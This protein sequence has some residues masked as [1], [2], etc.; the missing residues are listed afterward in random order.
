MAKS[1][2]RRGKLSSTY[3]RSIV[4]GAVR[5]QMRHI[6]LNPLG[7]GPESALRVLDEFLR[8]PDM[9]GTIARQFADEASDRQISLFC[10][11][12]EKSGEQSTG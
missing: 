7:E 2:G 12:W 10:R 1:F 3:V 4:L 11:E 9:A 6:G 5:S 8:Q